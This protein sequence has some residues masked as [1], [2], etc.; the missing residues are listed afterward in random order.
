[1]EMGKWKYDVAKEGKVSMT[2]IIIAFFK[3]LT[4]L[5]YKSLL[6]SLSSE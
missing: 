4:L 1:M 3:G 6:S 5:A 2:K